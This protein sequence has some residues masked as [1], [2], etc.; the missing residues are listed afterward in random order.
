MVIITVIKFQKHDTILN[1]GQ[2]SSALSLHGY[3]LFYFPSLKEALK[4]TPQ[5]NSM[6]FGF[7][8]SKSQLRGYIWF[9]DVLCY[10]F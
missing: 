10:I 4:L 7:G 8:K 6:L 3:T 2:Q 1:Q 5:F 9:L